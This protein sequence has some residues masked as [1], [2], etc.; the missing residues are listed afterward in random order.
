[1]GK[2]A[3][4]ADQQGAAMTPARVVT[5]T[6][7]DGLRGSIET[8]SWP[9]DGSKPEVLV[10]LDDGRQVLVPLEAL[11]RQE[12]GSYA[13][14]LDPAELEARHGTGSNVSGP[15]LVVPLIVE[16]LEIEK[17]QVETGR[18]RISKVVHEREEVID[19]P[20][21]HEEVSI[22]R[23]P[24][25]RFVDE[26]IPIRY[27]GDTMIVSLLEEVP[28]VE[29]RLMLKEELWITKRQVEAH[30]PVRVTLRSEETTV[31]HI[32]VEYGEIDNTTKTLGE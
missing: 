5:V 1:M 32:D 27:E 21:L 22:A 31:E 9:L 24:T 23:V 25:N 16:E 28:V 20:L 8:A 10:Q 17:R 7:A 26:A 12:D 2:P 15:P 14:R 29:K 18:V 19:E 4:C 30:K 6:S 3:R 13:L 11:S